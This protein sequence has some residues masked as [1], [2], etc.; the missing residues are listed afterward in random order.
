MM[1]FN[2]A[3]RAAAEEIHDEDCGYDGYAPDEVMTEI[4]TKHFAPLAELNAKLVELAT[5]V[6]QADFVWA[7]MRTERKIQEMM[8][9]PVIVAAIREGDK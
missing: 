6:L 8:I 5:V 9:D 2:D 3:A 1:N 4:I 7:D